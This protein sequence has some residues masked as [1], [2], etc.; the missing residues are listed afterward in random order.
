MSEVFRARKDLRRLKVLVA[1]AKDR[2]INLPP[3]IYEQL[4]GKKVIQEFLKNEAG[5][6]LG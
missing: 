3:E 4:S 2:G 5:Y 1:E 6:Y